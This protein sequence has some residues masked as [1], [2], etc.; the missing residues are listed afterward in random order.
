MYHLIACT[1]VA[2]APFLEKIM[3]VGVKLMQ[4]TPS[5]LLEAENS[6]LGKQTLVRFPFCVKV[7]CH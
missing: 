6:S 1:S 7:F 4:A 3:P 2:F 5:L